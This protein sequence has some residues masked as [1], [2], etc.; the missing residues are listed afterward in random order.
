[1]RFR[2]W[3]A[4]VAIVLV[5]LLSASGLAVAAPPPTPTT[6]TVTSFPDRFYFGG[7]A[8]VTASVEPSNATGTVTVT[9]VGETGAQAGQPVVVRSGELFDGVAVLAVALPAFGVN[10]LSVRY[11]GDAGHAPAESNGIAMEQ[12]G[13][14]GELLINEVRSSGP[15][16]ADD[17]YIELYNTGIPIPLGDFRIQSNDGS[18]DLPPDAP[19]LDTGRSF[20]IAGPDFSLGAN[21][22]PDL[23][24]PVGHGGWQVLTPDTER[25]RTDVV[26]DSTGSHNGDPLAVV[27][28]APAEQWAFVRQH[29]AGRPTNTFDNRDDMVL[30][31][32]AGGRVGGVPALL[33]TPAPNGL[34]DPYPSIYQ[35][36]SNP[37]DRGV[38]N[39]IAPNRIYAA[40]A[41]GQLIVMRTLTNISDRTI[42]AAQ[43]RVTALSQAGGPPKPGARQPR[44]PAQLH[45]VNAYGGPLSR[46]S[47]LLRG[48]VWVYNLS[49]DPPATGLGGGLN[50]TLS[51]PLP[52]GGLAPGHS[53]DVS[54]S[55]AVDAPGDF[56]FGYDLDLTTA[57]LDGEALPRLRDLSAPAE[58]AT[59][60]SWST[61][62]L[63]PLR[64]APSS[65]YASGRLG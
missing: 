59:S 7:L 19:T 54:F 48:R 35:M 65:A 12:A 15:G 32:T 53:V 55:L 51:V 50:T 45:V 31:S 13:Y 10:H 24:A 9:A 47:T 25:T 1:M 44:E 34:A 33:G 26:G 42:T 36:R 37:I 30:V 17:S 57:P 41:P 62:Q 2:T 64:A 56:W 28:G 52:T 40:G 20:L 58:P 3:S 6:L 46:V 38:G 5:H 14:P 23:V 39:N 49:P 60:L 8:T 4:V 11:D 22:H 27:D 21:A 61:R 63:R 16:G 18:I 29:A 43:A